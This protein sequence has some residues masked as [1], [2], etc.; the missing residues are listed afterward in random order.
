MPTGGET[1]LRIGL[2]KLD[3]KLIVLLVCLIIQGAAA[4]L[5]L[6]QLWDLWSVYK[7]LSRNG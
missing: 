2:P 5:I 6:K 1:V 4:C 7:E 3:S